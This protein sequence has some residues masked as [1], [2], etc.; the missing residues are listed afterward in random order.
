LLK[1]DNTFTYGD[2][3]KPRYEFQAQPVYSI[4]TDDGYNLVLR[5]ILPITGAPSTSPA[6]TNYTWGLG[7]LI[8]QSFFVPET[9]SPI[10]FGIGPQVS[11]ETRTDSLL[12]GPGWGGGVSAV[13][14]GFAGDLAYGGIAGHHWGNKFSVSTIQPIVF[15]N[16]ELFDGSYIGY[17]NSI[18]YNWNATSNNGLLAP[19]GLTFGKTFVGDAVNID[20]NVGVYGLAVSPSGGGDYQFKFALSA[21]FN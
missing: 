11:M 12:A 6:G 9:D 3:S 4:N 17:S 2:D 5:G 7:D 19:V 16:M 8:V 10:K 20:F 13:A 21:F 1:T 18:T 14:F 15:Y